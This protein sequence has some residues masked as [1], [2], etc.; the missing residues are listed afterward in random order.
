MWTCFAKQGQRQIFLATWGTPFSGVLYLCPLHMCIWH[1]H[2]IS[3]CN[4][5]FA[6]VVFLFNWSN[7][8]RSWDPV[9]KIFDLSAHKWMDTRRNMRLIVT[10]FL[11]LIVLFS[12]VEGAF[13]SLQD[14][15]HVFMS[16]SRYLLTDNILH[17]LPVGKTQIYRHSGQNYLVH[18]MDEKIPFPLLRN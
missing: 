3:I 7:L 12:V 13:P 2:V 11:E 10:T 5:Q 14:R 4:T 8:I 18:W 17:Y 6:W 15:N 16:M 9:C 1:Q